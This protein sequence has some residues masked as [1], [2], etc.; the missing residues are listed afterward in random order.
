M[1]VPAQLMERSARGFL[2]LR[3]GVEAR[4]TWT[5]QVTVPRG[6]S[7]VAS[8]RLDGEGTALPWA[9]WNEAPRIVWEGEDPDRLEEA[10]EGGGAE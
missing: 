5:V 3:E 8:L 10:A 9:S 2:R 7:E 6:G 1:T 4:V